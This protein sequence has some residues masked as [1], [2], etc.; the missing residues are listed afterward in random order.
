MQRLSPP[1]RVKVCR[2]SVAAFTLAEILV[3]VAIVVFLVV[4]LAQIISS[5]QAIWRNSEARTDAFRD[6]R[7]AIELISRDLSLALTNER[8]PVLA[9]SPVYSDP[10]DATIGPQHNRQ[11]YA[12]IPMQNV[13]DPPP[14]SSTRSDICAIGFYCSWDNTRRAYVLRKHILQSNPTFRRLQAA[15]GAP[16]P[17]PPPSPSPASTGAP[18]DPANVY[19]PSN[20]AARHQLKTKM[21]PRTYGI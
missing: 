17:T 14:G 10:N 6:A 21:Y 9:L 20:P 2:R 12:L 19:S 11:V 13:G 18:V 3:A 15:F 16:T 1:N 4:V 8:A 7:A 5:A